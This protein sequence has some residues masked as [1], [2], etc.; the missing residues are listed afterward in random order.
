M[1]ALSQTE[2]KEHLHYCPASGVFT[3]MNTK[4][5]RVSGTVAGSLEPRGYIIIS[6][7]KVMYRAHRLAFLY[8]TGVHPAGEVDHIDG[9]KDNNKF[10]NLRI[11]DRAGNCQN[12]VAARK[13]S[14]L[15]L[16]GVSF[17]KASGKYVAQIQVSG[18]KTGLGY[19]DTPEAARLAYVQA[20][21]EMHT[22]LPNR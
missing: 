11:T 14:K 15:G 5:G 21:Q 9:V 8:M 4:G 1:S 17:N 7:N 19:F 13:D 12:L 16:L 2:L 10:A 20:K 22:K 18:V 6:V 3:R